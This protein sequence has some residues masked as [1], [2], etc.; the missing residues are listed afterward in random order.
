MFLMFSAYVFI[1]WYVRIAA[2]YLLSL[3]SPSVCEATRE[4]LDKFS[5]NIFEDFT[6][7]SPAI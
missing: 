1:F 5:K 4:Q 6:E 2:E 7:T 3:L